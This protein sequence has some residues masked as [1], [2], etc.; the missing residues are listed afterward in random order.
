MGE[1]RGLIAVQAGDDPIFIRDS[2]ADTCSIAL[3]PES[4]AF[5]IVIRAVEEAEEEES[6]GGGE[7]TLLAAIPASLFQSPPLLVEDVEMKDDITSGSTVSA[8][9]QRRGGGGQN[10]HF[11][12]GGS[13][14][15]SSPMELVDPSQPADDIMEMTQLKP[16]ALTRQESFTRE[17]S[18]DQLKIIG[19]IGTPRLL[20]NPHPLPA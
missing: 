7:A 20:S 19:K 2:D 15:L 8:P 9:H 6:Q 1:R 12:R 4:T 17:I 10:H 13:A 11:R 3:T 5:S 16:M 18:V 14:A